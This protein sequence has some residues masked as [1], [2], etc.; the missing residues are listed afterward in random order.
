MTDERIYANGYIYKLYS[1]INEFYYLGSTHTTLRQRKRKHLQKNARVNQRV[2]DWIEDVG[3]ENIKII[4]LH[5]YEDLTARQLKINEDNV[6][7]EHLGKEHCLNCN[8]VYRTQ[9]EWREDNKEQIAEKKKQYYEDNK[10]K[11]KQYR[12]DNKEQILDQKKQYRQTNKDKIKQYYKDNKE[13]IK[14]YTE[15]NKDKIAEK[16]K[17]YYAANKEQKVENQK[18]YYAAN[19]EQILEKQGQKINCPVCN[20]EVSKNHFTRHEKS[21]KHRLNLQEVKTI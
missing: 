14:Q 11:I 4:E 10:D 17:Q 8:R 13:R 16:K 12:E 2:N 6:I 7:K 19:R 18:Q 9:K 15:D 5:K 21:Q 1:H 20:C 3:T